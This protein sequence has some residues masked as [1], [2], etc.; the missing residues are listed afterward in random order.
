MTQTATF[1]P[2][3]ST[4]QI[5]EALRLIGE[6]DEFKGHW[7]RVSEIRAEQLAQLRQVTTIES[8]ASSTRIEGAEL[9]DAQVARVLSG[10][11]ADSFRAR[12]Q[13]EVRGYGDLMAIIYQSHS[14]LP[15]T[16]NHLKQ[17]HTALL[18]HSERDERHRG[19]YKKLPNHVQATH[20]N[21]QI[22]IL[23]H[24]ASPF[25]TPRLM[26]ELV[27]VT[28]DAFDR[29]IAHPL[30]VTARFVVEL[31]AIHPFQDGNG[32][33]AR[34]CTTLL[35]LRSGYD[36]V[37]YSSLERVVE[38]NKDGYYS[39]LRESQLAIR[40]NRLAFGAWLLFFLRAL[41]VQKRS[42]EAKL[43]VE[44]SML[45][46]SG[47]QQRILEIITAQGRA[48][49]S[50]I[51]KWLAVPS[52]T[53]RYNLEILVAHRLAEAHGERRGRYY[54]RFTGNPQEAGG[55]GGMREALMEVK[56]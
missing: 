9:T 41:S 30:V 18:R 1:G 39:A 19:E 8:V 51:A 50:T 31:L 3:L 7:R 33:L 56:R 36:Y 25:D 4:E 46:L 28:A 15:L 32:R 42:L 2:D 47:L 34:A 35:L 11:Q 13:A 49:T 24:T 43:E 38:D 27:S 23:F 29:E 10:L 26:T 17:L 20:P 16:E 44:R 52:R 14:D 45:R 6:I 53:V 54:T 48:T 5:T 12:D 55:G 22:E 37:P 40:D 21:G